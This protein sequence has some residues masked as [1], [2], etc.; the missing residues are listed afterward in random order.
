[1]YDFERVWDFGCV[2]DVFCLSFV[3]GPCCHFTFHSVTDRGV[4][5]VWIIGHSYVAW[6]E[7]R[8]AIRRSG[9]QLG[10]PVDEALISWFGVRGLRWE[11]V[12]TVFRREA[13]RGPLP[14]VIVLH[15]GG[16]D[17]GT[18]PCRTLMEDIKR[19]IHVMRREAPGALI[20]W[21]EIVPRF[22]WRQARDRRAVDRARIKVNRAVSKFVVETRG[23]VARHED[24][25]NQRA[26]FRG[27]GVHL[28][29]V[30]TDFFNNLIRDRI[31]VLV[32]RWREGQR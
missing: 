10:F 26:L 32:E 4:C 3:L 16:N 7:R 11:S 14:G 8:A 12:L 13:A 23:M 5:R 22:S 20:L 1:M 9:R 31:E 30:G 19:D 2:L 18:V 6:A 24:L 25:E 27:D 29:D 15:A 21:S 28:T 17:L